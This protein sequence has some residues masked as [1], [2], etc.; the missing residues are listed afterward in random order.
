MDRMLDAC[1]QYCASPSEPVYADYTANRDFLLGLL[2]QG[3][4][5]S[6]FLRVGING[7]EYYPS[8]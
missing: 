4:E 5:S 1:L 3:V 2:R 6:E 7:N 8:Q